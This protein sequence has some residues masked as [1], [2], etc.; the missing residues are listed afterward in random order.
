MAGSVLLANK[1]NHIKG[2]NSLF[3]NWK[4][5]NEMFYCLKKPNEMDKLTNK[6]VKYIEV[7]ESRWPEHVSHTRGRSWSIIQQIVT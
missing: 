6:I 1:E 7:S 4:E 3:G 2:Q 5:T